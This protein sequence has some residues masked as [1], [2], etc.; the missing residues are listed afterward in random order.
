MARDQW[1]AVDR[2]LTELFVPEDAVLEAVVAASEEAGL[3][4]HAVSPTQGKL[5]WTLARMI[6]ARRILELG[7]LGGYSGIWLARALPADGR[8]ITLEV[9]ARRAE[10]A[11]ASFAR[12]GFGGTVEVRVGPALETLP[13]L[14]DEAVGPFDLTF[15]DADKPSYVEYLRWALALSR[16]G[17]VIVIDNVIRDGAVVDAETDDP[18]AQGVR[19][20][21][22]I[23]AA[24]P[25]LSAT[26][27][28]TVGSKGWDGFAIALVT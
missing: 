15:I 8:L 21:N 23:L 25:R 11:R 17:S 20:M 4:R 18:A 16:S 12:A 19:R 5:L 2:Y 27:I 9:D 7:T 13:R 22:A 10:V 6:G 28:Q 24:E 3:P 14:A 1:A 26:T